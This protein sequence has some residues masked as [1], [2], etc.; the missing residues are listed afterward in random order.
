MPRL[1]ADNVKSQAVRK[2]NT[3]AAVST[4]RIAVAVSLVEVPVVAVVLW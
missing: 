1:V 4:I 3:A 2:P